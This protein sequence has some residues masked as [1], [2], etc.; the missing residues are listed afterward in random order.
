MRIKIIVKLF[1]SSW[2]ISLLIYMM[3]GHTSNSKKYFR[4]FMANLKSKIRSWYLPLII[5]KNI[6]IIIIIINITVACFND[7]I[8]TYDN[9]YYIYNKS[10]FEEC[11][12][13]ENV[14]VTVA[15]TASCL[16]RRM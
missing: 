12:K 16:E 15:A 10:F 9:N 4:L 1:A 6:I 8:K 2:Y 3:H 5:V 13:E 14:E 7:V 11:D